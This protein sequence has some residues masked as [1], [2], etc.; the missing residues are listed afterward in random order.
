[1]TRIEDVSG[2]TTVDAPR[3]LRRP[4]ALF[5]GGSLIA[6][7]LALFAEC[8][9]SVAENVLLAADV[10]L[11]CAWTFLGRPTLAITVLAVATVTTVFGLLGGTPEPAFFQP[12]VLAV[13]VG[14]RMPE[15]HRSLGYAVLLAIVPPLGA[16]EIGRAHV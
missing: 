4:Q 9:G 12:I 7:M 2:K 15:L 5:A 16:F 11:I 13:A 8:C 3:W 6:A 1:M 10:L 14:W